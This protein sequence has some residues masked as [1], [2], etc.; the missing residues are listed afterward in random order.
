MSDTS[1]SRPFRGFPAKGKLTKIPSLFFSRLLPQIETMEE[2]KVTL[3]ALWFLEQME[4]DARYMSRADFVQDERF[5]QG[6]AATPSKAEKALSQGLS[7]AV[8]R[9]VLLIVDLSTAQGAE[10]YY[11]PNTPRGQAA[12]K[13]IRNGSW[14]PSAD[15]RQPVS[16]DL[17]QPGIF[18][19]YEENIGP[20]TPLIAESLQEAE[21]EYPAAWIEDA[22][23]SAVENNARSWRYVEAILRSRKRGERHDKSRPDTEED[24][25]RYIEGE[26]ADYIEH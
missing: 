22:M 2:L 7:R 26:F 15:H 19:L 4:G 9:G 6:L 11:F 23:R 5:M 14:R 25:R 3:Y 10:T 18:Q 16:L 24:R 13:A 1:S 12:L 21:K 17:D 8:K 20:L